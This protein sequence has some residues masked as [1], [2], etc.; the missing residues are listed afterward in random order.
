MH[1][2]VSIIEHDQPLAYTRKFLAYQLTISLTIGHRYTFR[3]VP[4]ARLAC[5]KDYALIVNILV[6]R[7]SP[8][9]CALT[10][11][12]SATCSRL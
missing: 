6:L 9:P 8:T 10:K 11:G 2:L 4:L 1:G 5:G 12:P 3:H 7:G